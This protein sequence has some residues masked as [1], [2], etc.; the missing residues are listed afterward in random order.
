MPQ[1]LQVGFFDWTRIRQLRSATTMAPNLDDALLFCWVAVLPNFQLGLVTFWPLNS[2]TQNI[3]EWFRT[4]SSNIAWN[5]HP[6]TD[7]FDPQLS[8]GQLEEHVPMHFLR[9]QGS[10][11]IASPLAL[12]GSVEAVGSRMALRQV[13][14]PTTVIVQLPSCGLKCLSLALNLG[15]VQNGILQGYNFKQLYTHTDWELEWGIFHCNV[16]IRQFKTSTKGWTVLRYAE[17]VEVEPE[18]SWPQRNGILKSLKWDTSDSTKTS[19]TNILWVERFHQLD[20]YPL[21]AGRCVKSIPGSLELVVGRTAQPPSFWDQ[22]VPEHLGNMLGVGRFKISESV[23]PRSSKRVPWSQEGTSKQALWS[24]FVSCISMCWAQ[25]GQW[26][27]GFA[28]AF[29]DP[30]SRIAASRWTKPPRFLA[31]PA[32]EQ[33]AEA[34]LKQFWFFFR[35]RCCFCNWDATIRHWN[36][37]HSSHALPHLRQ[38]LSPNGLVLNG[39]FLGP[40]AGEQRIRDKDVIALATCRASEGAASEPVSGTHHGGS[41]FSLLLARSFGFQHIPRWVMH[42]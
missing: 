32:W 29:Q 19:T 2:S 30:L 7:S 13:A 31:N 37:A 41:R 25:T 14:S 9:P 34:L 22:L 12:D 16:E 35:L 15:R 1:P 39:R 33:A 24:G 28:S 4:N 27:Q 26:C 5:Y 6:Q 23:L 8:L 20:P 11:R 42:L 10:Y 3:Q 17:G 36:I 18:E 38:C 21:A 40:D